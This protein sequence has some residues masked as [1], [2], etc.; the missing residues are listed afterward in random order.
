MIIQR[1]C[2][3]CIDIYVKYERS[4]GISCSHFVENG[5]F[6]VHFHYFFKTLNTWQ[7]TANEISI[8]I[9]ILVEKKHVFS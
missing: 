7:H 4:Y 6:H 9:V 2:H 1:Q 8:V 3:F 5:T